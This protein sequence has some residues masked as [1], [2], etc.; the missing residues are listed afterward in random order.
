VATLQGGMHPFSTD[1]IFIVIE[2]LVV[3]Q[4]RHEQDKS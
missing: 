3:R 2:L 4:A 1:V